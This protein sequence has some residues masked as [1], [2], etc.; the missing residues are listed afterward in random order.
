MDLPLREGL[1]SWRITGKLAAHPCMGRSG[2]W[3]ETYVRKVLH[4]RAALGEYQPTAFIDGRREKQGDPVPGYYPAVVTEAE[5]LAAQGAIASRERTT[6]RPGEN[7]ANLFTTVAKEAHTRASLVLQ[8][9]TPKEGPRRR[10]LTTGPSGG[11]FVQYDPLEEAILS[12]VDHLVPEDVVTDSRTFK[13][14]NAAIDG[15]TAERDA[16]QARLDFLRRRVANPKVDQVELP[17]LLD[18]VRDVATRLKAA[19]EE[20]DTLRLQATTGQAEALAQA[21]SLMLAM[22]T[23]TGERLGELRR[24]LKGELRLLIQGIFV[25]SQRVRPGCQVTHVQIHLANGAT[26]YLQV[27]PDRDGVCPLDLSAVDFSRPGPLDE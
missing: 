2:R 26:R 11:T 18:A 15:L 25:R 19:A 8:G 21:K 6:G 14:R 20:L 4:S 7:E 3:S 10:F 13:E 16:L 23:T 1:G 24:R 17:T 22:T 27:V 5:W 12:T 9:S